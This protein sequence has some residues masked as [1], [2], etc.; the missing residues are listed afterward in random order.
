MGSVNEFISVTDWK[1][2]PFLYVRGW[3]I[4]IAFISIIIGK[5]EP[6]RYN[7]EA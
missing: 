6:F 3:E 1:G 2:E 4:I 7:S 5:G